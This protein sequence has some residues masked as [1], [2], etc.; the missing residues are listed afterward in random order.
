MQAIVTRQSLQDLLNRDNR[1]FV[2]HVVGRALVV[3]FNNQTESEKCSDATEQD[4]G[5][6]FSGADARSGTLTAK[7]YIKN[8]RLQDWQVDRWLKPGSNGYAR[9]TKYAK[10]LNEAAIAKANKR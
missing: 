2:M 6:G 10:Q 8:G 3:L 1:E 5:I 7:S 9:L 4:N